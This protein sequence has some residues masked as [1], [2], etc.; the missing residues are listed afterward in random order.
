MPYQQLRL[1][2]TAAAKSNN[3]EYIIN[4]QKNSET[5]CN[6]NQSVNDAGF[7]LLHIAAE[8]QSNA[9]V[10]YLLENGAEINGIGENKFC[11]T[12]L[13]VAAAKN[14]IHAMTL[15]FKH[16]AN[17]DSRDSRGLTPLHCAA[18]YG[19]KDAIKFLIQ[20]GSKINARAFQGAQGV[21]ALHL[22]IN[23]EGF[24]RG[25]RVLSEKTEIPNND[26]Y[27]DVVVYLVQNCNADSRVKL[28]LNEKFYSLTEYAMQC[29]QYQIVEA[30][31]NLERTQRNSDHKR[32]EELET[33]VRLLEQQLEN[34]NVNDN[35]TQ[36]NI[37]Q[38][39]YLARSL[40]AA[41]TSTTPADAGNE[42]TAML[43]SPS[44][45]T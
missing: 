37:G 11:L 44:M 21:T 3:V 14:N 33:R 28:H 5:Y 2:L 38:A 39:K 1:D 24:Q 18:L 6:I 7:T 16:G 30:L 17:V 12:P 20:N 29:G 45:S 19:H 10:G 26:V 25:F 43:T 41:I 23:P 35:N 31:E 40:A 22:A 4:N 42:V 8:S 34:S 32:I 15:L 13:H 9:V 27:T 36:N